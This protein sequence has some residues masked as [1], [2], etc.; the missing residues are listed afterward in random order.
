MIILLHYDINASKTLNSNS[1]V[2][3]RLEQDIPGI[4]FRDRVQHS[5]NFTA[6][7]SLENLI[8]LSS[9]LNQVETLIINRGLFNLDVEGVNDLHSLF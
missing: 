1:Y 2:C 5:I 9:N 7:N 4:V 3:L 8:S 6:R